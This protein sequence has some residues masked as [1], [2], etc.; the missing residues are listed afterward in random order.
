MEFVYIDKEENNKWFEK[1]K[2]D[3]P[4]VHLNGK[5]LMKHKVFKD[6][7][8]EA[9]RNAVNSSNPEKYI[10]VKFSYCLTISV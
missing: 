10:L 3:I 7:L 9:I 1:Y 8:D 5:F 6:A 4:V 2:Y